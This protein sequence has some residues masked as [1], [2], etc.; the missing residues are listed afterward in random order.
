MLLLSG[1]C[2]YHFPLAKLNQK[3]T[4]MKRIEIPEIVREVILSRANLALQRLGISE[5]L[6]EINVTN[7][8]ER[9][10]IFLSHPIRQ[11]PMMFKEVKVEGRMMDVDAKEGDIFYLE[12]ER[13][14]EFY[15]DYTYMSFSNGHNG[16]EIG[17]MVFRVP[18]HLPKDAGLKEVD[19]LYVRT[20]RGLQL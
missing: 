14:I 10:Y 9:Q 4:I 16:T 11:F 13:V 17:Y 8:N 7:P 20:I 2:W 1:R 6:R 19:T 3:S 12:G 5:P 15:L 18:E